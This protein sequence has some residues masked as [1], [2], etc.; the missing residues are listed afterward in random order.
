M[1]RLD[2][3]F[4]SVGGV[5]QFYH[6]EDFLG[7]QTQTRQIRSQGVGGDKSAGTKLKV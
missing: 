1:R 5:L 2:L 3:K 4:A 6:E 7:L